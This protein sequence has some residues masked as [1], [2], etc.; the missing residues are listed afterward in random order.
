[1]HL[2]LQRIYKAW[3]EGTVAILLL[4]DVSGAYDNVSR[5]RLLHN[6]R[7]R[8]ICPSLVNWIVSFLSE[9]LTILKLREYTSESTPV[10]ERIPQGSRLSPILYLFYNADLIEAC[11]TDKTEAVGYI[12]DVS[13]LAIG[14]SAP[15]NCRTLKVAYIKAQDWA[16]KHGSQFAPTKY[17]LV[18]LNRDPTKNI[19]HALRLPHATIAPSTSAK[20]LGIQMDTR[21]RWYDQRDRIVAKATKRLSALSALASS[22]WGAG[23]LNLRLVYR[24]MLLPQMLY[25]CSAWYT[26]GGYGDNFDA[27]MAIAIRKMQRRAAQI[28]TGAFQTTAGAAVDV[29]AYLLPVYQ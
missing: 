21:L 29:E 11:Q 26:P 9:R 14:P 1:M 27:D 20:Y 10:Q 24:A 18:H 5:E 23:M 4:L 7:K 3:D 22:S 17:E 19:T 16:K 13:I 15:S 6:L 12:D 25:G 2:L 28:I 8:R